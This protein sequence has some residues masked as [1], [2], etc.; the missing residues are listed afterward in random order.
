L[1]HVDIHGHWL[2]QEVRDQRIFLDCVP[3]KQVPADGLTKSLGPQ[4][5][6]KFRSMIGL[7]A[8]TKR[9]NRELRLEELREIITSRFRKGIGY[10]V[11]RLKYENYERVESLRGCVTF[12]NNMM[13]FYG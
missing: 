2:G 13:R 10:I 8:E 9:L 11:Q 12:V 7:M 4:K 5:H 3:T 1:R 6:A